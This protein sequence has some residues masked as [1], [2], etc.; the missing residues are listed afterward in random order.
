V[1]HTGIRLRIVMPG[2][3]PLLEGDSDW[4]HMMAIYASGPPDLT[5]EDAI[6]GRQ[7]EQPWHQVGVILGGP[8]EIWVQPVMLPDSYP[9]DEEPGSDEG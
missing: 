6:S 8:I 2:A 1:S 7:P 5:M 3:G 4:L 9:D